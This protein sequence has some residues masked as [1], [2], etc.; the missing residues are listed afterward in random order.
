MQLQSDTNKS[1]NFV[2]D[3][4]IMFEEI[5]KTD[6][7]ETKENWLVFLLCERGRFSIK[8]DKGTFFLN[9]ND[10]LLCSLKS[11]LKNSMSS[12]DFKGKLVGIKEKL[13]RGMIPNSAKIWQTVFKMRQNC[14]MHL[15]KESV[16]ELQ[17]D[18]AYLRHKIEQSTNSY[19]SEMMRCAI[20]TL[21][22]SV[23]NT[24]ESAL[25]IAESKKMLQSKDYLAE[26]FFRLLA[27][28]F[29][30]PRCVTWYSDRLYKSPKYLSTVIRQISGR[31]PL[32]WITDAAVAEITDLLENSPKSIKEI[33]DELNF[34][35]LSY[36]GRYVRQHLGMSPTQYREK[37]NNENRHLKSDSDS[38][39][40]S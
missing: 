26:A 25:E 32:E 1:S 39:F 19:Y 9:A 40:G 7:P 13:G 16:D 36:F 29:P 34:P 2:S 8:L 10:L 4:F 37:L 15:S 23:S 27:E 18:Y 14:I 33:C 24:L 6:I 5:D 35:S 30:K 22:Y 28:T 31:T 11:V 17:I 3:S 21:I 38:P 20:Q 12:P